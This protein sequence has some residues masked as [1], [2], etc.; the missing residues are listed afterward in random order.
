LVK[1]ILI[2]LLAIGLRLWGLDF[3]LPQ[4]SRPDE[5]NISNIVVNNLLASGLHSGF[6]SGHWD[7]NP[8]FFEYP[9]LY[10]YVLLA[11]Y[12]L[13]YGLGLVLGW[14]SGPPDFLHHYL[15]NYTDF[16]LISRGLSSL[17]GIATVWA[18]VKVAQSIA[19]YLKK[20]DNSIAFK[21]LLGSL[22]AVAGALMAVTYLHVR[23]SHFGVTDVPATLLITLS[24]WYTVQAI[25]SGFVKPLLW[26]S[27]WAGLAASTKYPAGLA[28]VPI[29]LSLWF[30]FRYNHP[31]GT[32]Y[33][34]VPL[35]NRGVVFLKTT[36]VALFAFLM[37]SPFVILDFP[38][39]WADFTF[40]QAHMRDGHLLDVG[41]GWWFHGSFTLWYGLGA[42]ACV[43]TLL[44]VVWLVKWAKQST[45]VNHL[46]L[47]LLPY[48]AIAY[49]LIGNTKTVFLRYMIPL[50]PALVLLASLG[51]LW[52]LSSVAVGRLRRLAML[53]LLVVLL[54]QP[55]YLSLQSDQ[56]LAAPD[57]RN[58]ARSWI[59]SHYRQG[60]GVGIGFPLSQVQ[61]PLAIPKVYLGPVEDER[62]KLALRGRTFVPMQEVWFSGKPTQQNEFK[63]TSYLTPRA[64]QDI[65]VG[66]VMVAYSPLALFNA[67][68]Y[69]YEGMA[70]QYKLV[71]HFSPLS[72]GGRW[73]SSS[74][75]DQLDAL[76]L[77]FANFGN[78]KQAGPE[79]W[80]YEVPRPLVLSHVPPLLSQYAH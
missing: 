8:H 66:Y 18:V 42:G 48:T 52:M 11:L 40:Q 54:G 65:G 73:P 29:W 78:L 51:G 43:L 34:F 63:I 79:I 69:E 1:W 46:A 70:R 72:S 25:R 39:F 28:M 75:Y 58:Q 44:G 68:R 4:L 22:P 15:D 49:L 26:A 31:K 5:Q 6:F 74:G 62:S 19:I 56:L 24:L 21:P 2:A 33:G 38:K 50:L 20:T 13:Y 7:L 67:P 3:G 10:F 12:G 37:T 77:P 41:H 45:H 60:D 36:L 80:I 35:V 27:F 17:C 47:L 14:F 16:H 71:A 59:L 76:Y 9:S 55:L 64:L 23:D 53:G 57:T 61:L 30:C 32:V